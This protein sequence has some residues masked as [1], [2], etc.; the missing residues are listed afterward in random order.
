MDLL[1]PV[2]AMGAFINYTISE[3]GIPDNATS[4][5]ITPETTNYTINPLMPGTQYTVQ[6]SYVNEVGESKNNPIGTVCAMLTLHAIG[7][8]ASFL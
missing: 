2:F 5:S 7:K 1:C 3:L 8:C 6:V 4:V